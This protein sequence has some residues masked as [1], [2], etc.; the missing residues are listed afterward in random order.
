MAIGNQT[1]GRGK[2]YFSLFKTGTYTPEG[3]RYIGNTPSFN[4]TIDNQKLEHFSSDE[5]IRVKDKSII[6][7]TTQTGN[8]SCDD[9]QLE[10]LALFFFGEYQTLSQTSATAETE[11]FTDVKQGLTYQIGVTDSTPTGVRSLSNV[12]VKVGATTKAIDTDYTIDTEL[13]LLTIVDGGTILDLDDVIVT[14]DRAAR[15]RDQ[16]ISGT[17]QVEGSILFVSANPEGD[18]MDYLMPYVRLAP[19]GDFALKSDE[20]QTLNLN[21]EILTAPNRSAIYVDGRPYV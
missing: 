16:V 19:N 21:V 10:N 14:Y 7:E 4:V 18:K 6:L 8:M 15:S 12:V 13:G 20:W 3:Y 9:I 11:T 1:L 17:D 5:G 2:V